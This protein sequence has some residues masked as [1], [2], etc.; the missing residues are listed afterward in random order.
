M[1]QSAVCLH[2][3]TRLHP[4]ESCDLHPDD[5]PATL[6][7]AEGRERLRAHTWGSP[8]LRARVRAAAK[9]GSCAGIFSGLDACG[10]CDIA[11]GADELVIIAIAFLAVFLAFL[12]G[13]FLFCLGKKLYRW[14]TRPRPTGVSPLSHQ[15]RMETLSGQVVRASNALAAP[16]SARPCAA[17]GVQLSSD[18]ANGSASV[19]LVDGETEALEVLLDDGR[20]VRIDGGRC[21]VFGS[22]AR[23]PR[24]APAE[25]LSLRLGYDPDEDAEHFPLFPAD[26]AVETLVTMGDRVQLRAELAPADGVYRAVTHWV[27]V[28]TAELTLQVESGAQLAA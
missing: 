22:R 17:W 8:D 11:G 3:R 1:I 15:S 7:T 28:G 20:V 25:Y 18:D 4:D 23:H 9:A 16:L 12:L 5:P 24:S 10:G 2:C 27:V 26:R 19:V 6:W 13:S 14:W 21:R